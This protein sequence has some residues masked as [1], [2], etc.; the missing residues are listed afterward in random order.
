MEHEINSRDSEGCRGTAARVSLRWDGLGS[1]NG[2]FF[3]FFSSNVVQ[4]L[5]ATVRTGGAQKCRIR[6]LAVQ[7]KMFCS[8]VW[9]RSGMLGWH[10]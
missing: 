5:V 3:F 1:L 9:I 8:L 6:S 10:R 7:P 2:I 4:W